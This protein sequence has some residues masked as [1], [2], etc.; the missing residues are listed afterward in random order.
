MADEQ[1]NDTQDTQ[2][3]PAVSF[4]TKEEFT[5]FVQGKISEALAPKLRQLEQ[6]ESQAQEATTLKQQLDELKEQANGTKKTTEQK[7]EQERTKWEQQQ[8]ALQQ[9]ISTEQDKHR[10][11]QAKWYSEKVDN[12][13]TA[14]ASPYASKSALGD[15]ARLYPKDSIQVS[16]GEQGL[17]VAIVDPQTGLEQDPNKAIHEWLQTK[18]HLMAAPPRGAGA[19]G[20]GPPQ[21]EGRRDILDGLEPGGPQL[22]AGMMAEMGKRK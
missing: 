1:K 16:E 13:I 8:K 10:A 15:I 4:A 21:D 12:Y 2:E 11:T 7:W 6:L 3:A 14:L 17:K 5:S 22:L 9:Q 18:P 19:P 20:S